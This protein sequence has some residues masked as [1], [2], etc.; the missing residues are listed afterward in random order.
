M[1]IYI[2]INMNK[3]N[4]RWWFA[5]DALLNLPCHLH[6]FRPW[7][8]HDLI[9]FVRSGGDGSRK[10]KHQRRSYVSIE[11]WISMEIHCQA[12]WNMVKHGE[13]MVKTWWT[14]CETW[15]NMVKHET[16]WGFKDHLSCVYGCIRPASPS[17]VFTSR[18]LKW[19]AP[20]GW[21]LEN[22]A[23]FRSGLIGTNDISD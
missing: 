19:F 14:H 10:T 3:V 8:G 18:S 6:W 20:Q 5:I 12:R 4:S 21:K 2:Y 23:Q 15:W 16:S 7:P 17:F 1:Y 22:F 9:S 11:V 13:T